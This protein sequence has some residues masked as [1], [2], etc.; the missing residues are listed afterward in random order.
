MTKLQGTWVKKTDQPTN[1]NKNPPKN[2]NNIN[3]KSQMI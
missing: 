3:N 1:N 2:K